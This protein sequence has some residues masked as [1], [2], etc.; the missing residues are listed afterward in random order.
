MKCVK[1]ELEFHL[2]CVNLTKEE[3][4][5]YKDSQKPWY[6]Q[7]CCKARRASLKEDVS[8]PEPESESTVLSYKKKPVKEQPLNPPKSSSDNAHM[9][10]QQIVSM[11][12][13]FR[14]EV[15]VSNEKYVTKLDRH[16]S[17]IKDLS[18]HL[19]QYSDMIQQNTDAIN[20]LRAELNAMNNGLQELRD[21]NIVLEK[22]VTSLQSI[23]DETEQNMLTNAV[24]ITGI[25]FNQNESAIDLVKAVG[26]AINFEINDMM[27]NNCFRRQGPVATT[28]PGSVFL[29]FTRKLDKDLFVTTTRQQPNLTSRQLGFIEVWSLPAPDTAYEDY[30]ADDGGNDQDDYPSTPSK[31]LSQS[32]EFVVNIGATVKLPCK[33]EG[34]E[35]DI[36]WTKGP[37]YEPLFLGEMKQT[38]NLRYSM[39]LHDFT[40]TIVGVNISDSDVFHCKV[41]DKVPTSVTHT[42]K[43]KSGPVITKTVPDKERNEEK[44]G[45]P[46][47]FMCETA[48]IPKP[49][50]HWMINNHLHKGAQRLDSDHFSYDKLTWKHSGNYTCVAEQDNKESVRKVIHLTVQGSPDVVVA[51]KHVNSAEHYESEL[52]CNIHCSGCHVVRWEKDGREIKP[53]RHFTVL[54]EGHRHILRISATKRNDFGEYVC[55]AE[56]KIGRSSGSIQLRGQPMKPTL[57][58]LTAG[59]NGKSSIT[60]KIVSKADIKSYEINYKRQ[61]DDDWKA[62]TAE[63]Q[64]GN[65]G[66]FH[67]T[68]EFDIPS[69]IPKDTYKARMRAQNDY[70]FSELSD[71]VPFPAGGSGSD[72][73][74]KDSSSMLEKGGNSAS[75]LELRLSVM[76]IVALL[77]AR[78]LQ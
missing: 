10:M 5:F 65:N 45:T 7:T 55:I 36:Q 54:Q 15:R 70:G 16:T 14:E 2:D 64:P 44:E 66:I 27:I 26:R 20:R 67:L 33:I 50:V 75:H 39:D 53:D 17:E 48:G 59:E 4:K 74:P 52:I 12:D 8:F 11:I 32:Q 25:P 13:S 78:F 63:V 51:A 61:T 1:C 73:S 62:L 22:K 43:V 9:L 19:N 37:S 72:D 60:W 28:I 18:T 47:T 71:E 29:S 6:C 23:V 56:N 77:T 35:V 76:F 38:E 24:E 21:R 31:I 34:R 49:K 42:L 30:T 58:K 68:H 57:E 40:L 3:F 46:I 41:M 69:D